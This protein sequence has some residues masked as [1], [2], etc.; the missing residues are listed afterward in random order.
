MPCIIIGNLITPRRD[1]H[2]Y[3]KSRIDI[4][5]FA[6]TIAEA[7]KKAASDIQTLH[8]VGFIKSRKEDN[9]KNARQKKINRKVSAK[10]LLR[11]FLVKERGLPDFA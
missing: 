3:D 1:P 8:A 5:P 9:Y 7:V 2:G 11:Q 6:K 10:E 4:Q